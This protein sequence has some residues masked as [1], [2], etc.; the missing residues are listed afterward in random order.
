[1][2]KNI[3]SSVIK[4]V[5]KLVGSMKLEK[6]NIWKETNVQPQIKINKFELLEK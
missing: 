6:K 2:S 3:H 1:M 5:D 4:V